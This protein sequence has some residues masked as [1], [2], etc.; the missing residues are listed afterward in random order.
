VYF[1]KRFKEHFGIS[2]QQYV[3]DIRIQRAKQLLVE[4]S[5]SLSLIAESCGVTNQYHFSRLF[6]ERTGL[7]PSEY[8]N[9]NLS[10]GI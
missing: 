8:R 2:P 3:I 7:A 5:L 9:K 1:R 6:K 4:G 10:Y